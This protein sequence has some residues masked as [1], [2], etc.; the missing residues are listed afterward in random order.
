MMFPSSLWWWRQSLYGIFGVGWKCHRIM[1]DPYPS[2]FLLMFFH[3]SASVWLLVCWIPDS[4]EG[5]QIAENHT[6]IRCSILGYCT[7][8][9]PNSAWHSHRW[10]SRSRCHQF[11]PFGFNSDLTLSSDGHGVGLSGTHGHDI[12]MSWTVRPLFYSKYGEVIEKIADFSSQVV[13]LR[14]RYHW[15]VEG[16]SHRGKGWSSE[17][18]QGDWVAWLPDAGKARNLLWECLK[19]MFPHQFPFLPGKIK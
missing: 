5:K 7:Y 2:L 12:A 10:V 8:W 18:H 4:D 19:H 14:F 3:R 17:T 1:L 13:P 9:I 11:F 15:P 6:G 16:E